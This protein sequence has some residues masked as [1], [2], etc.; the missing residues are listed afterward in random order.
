MFSQKGSQWSV[1]GT[2]F[3]CHSHIKVGCKFPPLSDPILKGE[4]SPWKTPIRISLPSKC[5]VQ[6]MVLAERS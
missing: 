4:S 6:S 3:H 2:N 1:T 5:C